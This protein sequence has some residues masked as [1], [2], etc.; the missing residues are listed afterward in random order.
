MFTSLTLF[1]FKPGPAEPISGFIDSMLGNAFVPCGA[2]QTLSIGWVP[3]RGND[4]DL[5][6]ELIAGHAFAR[7]AI[8]TK[9]VPAATIKAEVDKA[10]E[11]HKRQ[12]GRERVGKKLKAE[13]KADAI[14]R[15]LP[16]AFARRKEVSVWF[17]V[18]AGRVGIDTSSPS[19]SDLVAT[20]I[21]EST[22]AALS[23]INTVRAVT[24][25]MADQ[26]LENDSPRFVLGRECQLESTGEDKAKARFT[27]HSLDIPVVA[28]HISGGKQ[29]ASLGLGNSDVSFVLTGAM[30]LKKLEVGS[31][32]DPDRAST[33]DAF[34]ADAAIF[35]GTMTAAI[36]YLIADL[37]GELVVEG[38]AA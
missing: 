21:V 7:V 15:L 36:D 5:L 26:L 1:K 29:V 34:D 3:P 8:E 19:V 24:G 13:F 38:G 6:L 11:E 20:L 22:G 16:Q 23:R 2:T 14:L 9:S 25:Y 33:E 4:G 32:N 27:N 28:E 30:T 12:T 35:A 37:G 31:L 10:V 18:A 17:D